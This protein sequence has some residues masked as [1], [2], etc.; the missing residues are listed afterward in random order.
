MIMSKKQEIMWQGLV[1]SKD[2]DQLSNSEKA[3]VLGI[4]NQEIY[5]LERA[6]ILEAQM[7]YAEVEPRPLIFEKEKKGI[8]VPLYQMVMAVAASFVLGFFL[9]KSSQTSTE[10][11]K[12]QALATTDTVYVE[13]QIIDTVIQTKTEYIIRLEEKENPSKDIQP[14]TPSPSAVLSNQ[15]NFEADLSDATLANKGKSASNDETLVFM[16]EWVGPK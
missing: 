14:A 4:S 12:N 8:V 5:D 11:G 13:K 2:F 3:F 9:F 7:I 6:S 15:T 10:I 16:E 1:E